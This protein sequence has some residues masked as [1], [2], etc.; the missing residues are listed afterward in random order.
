MDSWGKF[1]LSLITDQQNQETQ[2]KHG[3]ESS[4]Q[5]YKVNLHGG[6]M[7]QTW[8]SVKV[9]FSEKSH[10]EWIWMDQL[11]TFSVMAIRITP[12]VHYR[13]MQEVTKDHRTS[14]SWQASLR[15]GWL[16]K[17]TSRTKALMK[18]FEK[19]ICSWLISTTAYKNNINPEVAPL[20]NKS[21]SCP[22]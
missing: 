5:S 1:S 18:I 4:R 14:K 6:Y 10:Y 15:P 2:V 22:L 13:L 16:E 19:Q 20:I 3:K 11:K 8:W 17:A 12:G 9:S 7:H 21:Q